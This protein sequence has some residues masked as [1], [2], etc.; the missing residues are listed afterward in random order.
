M[1]SLVLNS[2]TKIESPSHL[3]ETPICHWTNDEVDLRAESG[4]ETHADTGSNGGDPHTIFSDMAVTFF[5]GLQGSCALH[6]LGGG[7]SLPL[8]TEKEGLR[9]LPSEHPQTLIKESSQE[10]GRSRPCP[11]RTTCQLGYLPLWFPGWCWNLGFVHT[12]RGTT[13]HTL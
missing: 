12:L 11:Q 7:F 10:E 3:G 5:T 9:F 8:S 13:S 4:A 2:M 6:L 1:S